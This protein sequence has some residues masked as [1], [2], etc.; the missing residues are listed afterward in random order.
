MTASGSAPPN[1]HNPHPARADAKA[2]PARQRGQ[3]LVLGSI[4]LMVVM[5]VLLL[6]FN[7]AQLTS[8]RMQLQNTADAT[9]YSAATV[10]A[11]D[12]NF[13]AYMNRAMV[14]NQV[15]AA[16]MVGLTS[17]FRFTGQTLDNIAVVC[18]PI[19]GLDVICAALAETYEEFE[20]VFEDSVLPVLMNALNYW[21]AALSDLQMAFHYGNVEAIVQNVLYSGDTVQTGVLALNDPDASVTHW[22]DS[23]GNIPSELYRLA[24]LTKDASQW[25]DYTRRYDESKGDDASRFADVTRDSL[26]GFSNKRAWDL[27]GTVANTD[28]IT[29]YIPKWLMDLLPVHFSASMD[30]GIARRGGTEL[31]RVDGRH[32]WSAA[33]TLMGEGKISVTAEIICGFY[34][35]GCEVRVAHHCVIPKMCTKYCGKTFHPPTV[36]IPFGW[37]AAYSQAPGDSALGETIFN[38]GLDGKQYGGAA[39]GMAKATF[40]IA[41]GEFGEIPVTSFGGLQPYHE[42]A[43]PGDAATQNREGPELTFVVSKKTAKTRTAARAGF[44]APATQ[45]GP[46]GLSNLRLEDP[47]DPDSFY[48]IAKGRLHFAQDGQYSN[49]FG[50]YWEAKLADTTN[51]ERKLAYETLF[52]WKGFLHGD[53]TAPNPSGLPSYEP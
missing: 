8:T 32:S 36:Y 27:S 13:S 4:L 12:Y 1:F 6:L 29:R 23:G 43:K 16:Q 50:P 31:K 26:D 10:A 45:P 21:M 2:H 28:W 3:S 14:A 5:V 47:S 41:V 25:W 17:W 44:G 34:R 18:A 40:E 20:V 46:F 39:D 15:A 24:I 48:A 19:P 37:G 30:L 38:S 35:C 49:L 51:S 53:F 42:I 11:R 33:D 22:P 9:A 52:G 7:T